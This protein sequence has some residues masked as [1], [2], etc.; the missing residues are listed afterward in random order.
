MPPGAPPHQWRIVG[1]LSPWGPLSACVGMLRPGALGLTASFQL[2]WH[3]GHGRQNILC[4]GRLSGKDGPPTGRAQAWGGRGRGT[5]VF[6]F[7]WS[8][9]LLAPHTISQY[10]CVTVLEGLRG[11]PACYYGY[12]TS[13]SGCYLCHC[14]ESSLRLGLTLSRTDMAFLSDGG[15]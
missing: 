6:V 14:C 10:V 5:C 8:Q 13:M 4:V 2:T 3:A 15:G 7:A 9:I 11:I 1:D 12:G